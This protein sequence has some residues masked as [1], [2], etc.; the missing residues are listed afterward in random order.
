M[1]M[2]TATK[3]GYQS[4]FGN[5]FATEAL[6]GALPEGRNSPQKTPYGLY[7][8][9]ISGTAFTQPRNDNLRTWL[10][11][12][13]PSSQHGKFKKI[14][15]KLWRTPTF[16]EGV[17][18][19]QQIRWDPIPI[20]AEATDLIAGIKTLAGNGDSKIQ[21]GIGIHVY[22]ANVSMS[23]RYFY[24]A[25]GEMLF[26]P[27]QGCLRLVTEMGVV[28]VVPGQIA[29]VPRGIRFCV[30]LPNGPSRGYVCENFGA[31]LR[32]PDLG[33][34]GSNG[35]ANPRDFLAPVASFEDLDGDFELVVKFGGD[36]WASDIDHS[37]LDVVAWH[38]NLTPY[39]YDL[40]NFMSI[41]SIS[42]DH[43][44][45][46]IFTVL[47]SPSGPAGL[48]NVDF[49]IFPPRWLVA[50]N[51]FRPPW[52]HRNFMSEFMG[53][54]HGHYDA[55]E[56]G[57]VPGGASLHNMHSAHGP[58]RETYEKATKSDLKPMHLADTM[59]FMFETRYPIKLTEW[60]A[61]VPQIQPDYQ[62]CWQGL[63]KN[64]DGKR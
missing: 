44:D 25:D 7:T 21:S 61:N 11:R 24:N 59:A 29:V 14:D 4:G 9:L 48:A 52:Y 27:Q 43:P 45:P 62:D 55:K 56:E 64:F 10:Y 5:E 17:L 39:K 51:T 28:E 34:I 31:P 33:P 19:P 32:L 49:V 23:D 1:E 50:E 40:D 26:V 54:V 47:T 53:L 3:V 36:L 20:P 6:P 12:I 8:E 37:P 46:S 60:G 42:F 35:L 38:G 15:K 57:F 22:C 63:S 58:D 16:D 2:Q 41:G 30:G 18:T 13:R